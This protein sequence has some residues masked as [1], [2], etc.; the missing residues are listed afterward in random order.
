MAALDEVSGPVA[1]A[2]LTTAR[3]LASGIPDD[4]DE[5]ARAA[6]LAAHERLVAHLEEAAAGEGPDTALG[7]AGLTALMG[8]AEGM[9]LDLGRLAERADAE[10][11]RLRSRLAE[12]CAQI[13]PAGRRSRSRTSSSVIIPTPA[14]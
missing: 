4:A 9:P 14:G 7:T 10:R 8:S 11:D 5:Q 6:A 12:S 1:E 13:D 2:L 3:G